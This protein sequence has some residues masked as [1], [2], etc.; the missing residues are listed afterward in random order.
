MTLTDRDGRRCTVRRSQRP[1]SVRSARRNPCADV[2][3][4]RSRALCRR[5]GT[6]GA[7]AVGADA[8]GIARGPRHGGDAAGHR[9]LIAFYHPLLQPSP[10]SRERGRTSPLR[11]G[12]EGCPAPDAACLHCNLPAAAGRR[13]CCP[14]CAAAYETI[15][16]LGL[17]RYYTQRILDPALRAPRPEPAEPRDSPAS[18]PTIPTAPTN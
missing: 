15:Q 10:A 14:G 11:R 4:N 8:I 17:G 18:S 9:A 2:P 1:R 12:G 5:R 13:F 16:T 7:R 3:R 6:A